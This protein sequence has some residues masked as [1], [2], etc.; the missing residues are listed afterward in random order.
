MPATIDARRPHQAAGSRILLIDDEP[1]IRDFVS[2]ALSTSGYQIDL[3]D[4]GIEGLSQALAGD[5]HLVILD[6]VMPDMDGTSVLRRLLRDRPDQPVLVLSC[7]D[8]VTTKVACLE[9]GAQDYLAKPFSLDELLARVRVRLRTGPHS[10]EI[11]RVGSLVLD[12]WRLQADAG[13]GPVPLTRLEFMLL[14]ELMDRAGEPVPK[15]ELLA[16]VWGLE[17]DPGTNVV[18]VCVRR[19]RSKLGYALIKTVRGGGYWLAS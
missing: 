19:I 12:L 10:T 7:L 11:L 1:R 16:T 15:E 17:F 5:Y 6:L 4:G 9:L 18:D 14:R 2:R 13:S 3:A 8:D